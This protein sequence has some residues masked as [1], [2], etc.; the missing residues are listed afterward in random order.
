MV[1]S[2]T[3]GAVFDT[4]RVVSMIGITSGS[5]ATDLGCG[6]GYV[7]IALARAVG[8]QGAVTAIDV[9]EEPLQAVRAKAE[10]GGFKNVI[11]VRANL[12]VYGN[13][14]L[15]DASQDYSVLANVLFQSTQKEHIL[16]EAVRILKPGGTLAI[17][18]W[19]KG[20][21]GFGPPDALRSDEETLKA[22]SV[23]A[24]AHFERTIDVGEYYIGLLFK[25]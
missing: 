6:S 15:A 7:T 24:G 21:P 17:I 8:P 23:A 10:A 4:Q 18:D 16:A 11:A 20:R 2:L 3:S 14:K 9:M 13:T 22:L 25:K 12:E 1:Q 5:K 19:K